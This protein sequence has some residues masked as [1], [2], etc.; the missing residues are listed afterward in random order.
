LIQLVGATFAG[1]TAG[2]I[3]GND[4]QS[5]NGYL[6]SFLHQLVLGADHLSIDPGV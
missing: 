5:G 3:A 1:K 4:S 6:Q 2:K